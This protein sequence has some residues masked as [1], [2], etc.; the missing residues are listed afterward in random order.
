MRL[1]LNGRQIPESGTGFG[2]WRHRS[3]EAFSAAVV[4]V[5][6]VCVGHSPITI[7]TRFDVK[8][9]WVIREGI[10]SNLGTGLLKQGVGLS[11]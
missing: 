9:D 6:R 4:Q 7:A 2:S 5:V 11:G 1:S 8:R 10:R 3:R